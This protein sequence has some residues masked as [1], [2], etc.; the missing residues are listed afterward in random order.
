VDGYG[1]ATVNVAADGEVIFAAGSFVRGLASASGDADLGAIAAVRAAAEGLDLVEPSALRVLSR[2]GGAA[3]RTVVSRGGVSDDPIPA[4][5]GWQATA[6]GLRLAWQLTIADSSSPDLWNATV[7]AETGELLGA[8][9]WTSEDT[10]AGLASALARPGAASSASFSAEASALSSPNP[11]ADGSSYRVFAL[12]K[13]SPNDGPRTLEEN[14][15]DATASP[16][17]WHD[18][19]GAVGAEFTTARGNNV[20]AYTDH[21]NDNAPTGGLPA[22]VVD[23]SSPAAGTYDAATA[24]FGPAPTEAGVSGSFVVVNDG[25]GTTSDGCEAF[26]LPAGSIPLIDRGNCNL[27]S[28]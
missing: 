9:N 2:S 27:P 15:A 17:G 3:Q 1:H 16:F 24:A 5:L 23:P 22:V 14:P 26:T 25:V 8:D 13:E 6:D 4:R 10:Q 12:P 11:V 18:T 19:D 20:H 21:N 7:D 28:R